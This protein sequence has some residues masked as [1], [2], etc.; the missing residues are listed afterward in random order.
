MAGTDSPTHLHATVA[1]VRQ[2]ISRRHAANAHDATNA[3]T[4]VTNASAN[5]TAHD[6]A[7]VPS[8][9]NDGPSRV[10]TA[11][12]TSLRIFASALRAHDHGRPTASLRPTTADDDTANQPTAITSESG[13]GGAISEAEPIRVE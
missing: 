12:P 2:R 11:G 6:D 3:A 13:G 5:A 8:T 9:A 7:F 10:R 1:D 4:H